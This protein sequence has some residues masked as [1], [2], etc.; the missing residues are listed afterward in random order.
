M[1]RFAIG[2]ILFSPLLVVANDFSVVSSP[3]WNKTWQTEPVQVQKYSL[4]VS[5]YQH[6]IKRFSF[7]RP[8]SRYLSLS[9][10]VVTSRRGLQDCA[11]SFDQATLGYEIM[12]RL[13]LAEELELGLGFARLDGGHMAFITGDRL[14]MADSHSFILSTELMQQQSGSSLEIRLTR[15]RYDAHSVY[16][17]QTAFTDNNF[18]LSY[19]LRF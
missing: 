2:V 12:P 15:T 17:R 6:E 13:Q 19:Q 18:S 8:L 7:A 4:G 3:A 5:D 1:L 14:D 16:D 10:Q 11:N 9:A